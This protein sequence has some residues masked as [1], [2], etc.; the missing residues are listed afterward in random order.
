M[1][2]RVIQ[3]PV[4][5]QRYS[6]TRSTDDD[7]G[8]VLHVEMWVDP[9]GGV[10][11]HIHPAMEERFEVL[12]GRAELLAGKRWRQAAPGDVVTVPPGVRHA[13]RNRGDAVAHL[14]CEARPPSTLQAFLEEVAA[15]N[16]SGAF[17]RH[18]LPR[19]AGAL[20]EAAALVQRHQAMVV[21][22]FPPLPPPAVQRLVLPPL[23]RLA[24]R[25]GRRGGVAAV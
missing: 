24:E 3:D 22:L 5:R 15:L 4:L 1:A 14:R 6:F 12:E 18:G 13:Y 20:L 19:S 25:R 9:G 7:G 17:T 2:E 10:T 16:R 8:E 11:P 21:L 23:A